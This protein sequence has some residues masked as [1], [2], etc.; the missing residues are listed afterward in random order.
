MLRALGCLPNEYAYFYYAASDLVRTLEHGQTRGE[1]VARIRPRSTRRGAADPESAAELWRQ[2]RQRREESY[3]AETRSAAEQRDEAD[4][5]GGGYEHVALDVIEALLTGRPHG[6]DRQCA[7][8]GPRCPQLPPD[9]VLEVPCV[10][11]R[12]RCQS[13]AGGAARPASARADRLG[14]GQR[15]G[16]ASPPCCSRSREQALR[17]FVIHPLVGSPVIAEQILT[18][19]AVRRPGAPRSLALIRRQRL[20]PA[21]SQLDQQRD[22]RGPFRG[23]LLV[24]G[25]VVLR[26]HQQALIARTAG[27][28]DSTIAAARSATAASSSASG[29]LT[30]A[31]PI[32]T[33]S[34]A[35]HVTA[36]RADLQ[37]PL[38]ADQLEQ[39][40]GAAQVRHQPVTD[41]GHPELGVVGDHDQVAGQR[42]LEPGA[43][44]MTGDGGDRDEP[45]IG[46]PAESALE[47]GDG[48][49]GH[50]VRRAWRCAPSSESGLGREGRA[51]QTGRERRSLTA[52]N[53]HPDRRREAA[54]PMCANASQVSGS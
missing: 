32:R 8:T 17:A 47:T 25:V 12:A 6:A 3:L 40:G 44:R 48:L 22:L 36:G 23:Q 43:D 53:D 20:S 28:G 9:M 18:C 2:T 1:V 14:P 11:R 26:G 42:Q 45:R 35:E 49:V 31:S 10:D 39:P 41:L 4:L 52:D 37:G 38:I 21:L 13:A 16:G 46:Q 24:G 15:A 33:A 34:S 50:R 29:T 5:T 54:D 51:V 30:R 27:A 7:A 19:L